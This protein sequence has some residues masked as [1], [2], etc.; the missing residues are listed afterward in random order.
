MDTTATD[1]MPKSQFII[2]H[3]SLSNLRI[4][5]D[6]K[7]NCSNNLITRI[8]AAKIQT[9]VTSLK[10]DGD[11]SYIVEI[12]V[13][14]ESA[15]DYEI[16][17]HDLALEYVAFVNITDESLD[18]T[19]IQRI[20]NSIVPKL[21]FGAI[22]AIVFNATNAT[23]YPLLLDRMIYE[24][25]IVDNGIKEKN[26]CG[27]NNDFDD[28]SDFD[29][30]VIDFD[31]DI[32]DYQH[33]I[34]QMSTIAEANEFFAT[35][36]KHIGVNLTGNYDTVPGYTY[37]HRFFIPIEYNHPDFEDCDDSVWPLLFQLLFGNFDA[38]CHIIDKGTDL[39]EIAFSYDVYSG[40]IS[41]MS[42]TDLKSMLEDLI[43]DMLVNISVELIGYKAIN[44]EYGATINTNRLIRKKE[45]FKLYG[46]YDGNSII[47]DEFLE[48]MYYRIKEC[49]IKTLMYRH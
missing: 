4:Y 1:V 49:D 20:L 17:V 40:L 45:F 38:T 7:H 23:G 47:D 27:Y 11:Y 36:K 5:N 43:S 8:I 44:P 2:T 18:T 13:N 33:I 29:D 30:N 31:D 28:E 42:K 37:Y 10:R 32:I 6:Q 48:K 46:F 26:E 16:K 19:C 21:L 35:Y 41:D 9:D 3:T 15:T 34:K 25:S 14:I 24:D 39:P 22:N 12:N